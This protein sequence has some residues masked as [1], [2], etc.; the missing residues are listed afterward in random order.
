MSGL[1]WIHTVRHSDFISE[2][3]FGTKVDFEKNKNGRLQKSMKI[4]QS[5]QYRQRVMSRGMRFPK[6]WYV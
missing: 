3:F 1:I 4:T 2:C 6:M 5:C